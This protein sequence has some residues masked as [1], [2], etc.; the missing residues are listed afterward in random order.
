MKAKLILTFLL[1]FITLFTI[2]V[3]VD[4]NDRKDTQI[5]ALKA[6]LNLC[7][8]DNEVYF[9]N[10]LCE[11]EEWETLQAVCPIYKNDTTTVKTVAIDPLTGEWNECE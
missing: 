3:M 6:C 10:V 1:V 9:Y 8:N 7:I 4:S 11:T 5:A 2:K